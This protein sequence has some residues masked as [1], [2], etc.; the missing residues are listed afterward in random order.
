[1]SDILS[2]LLMR[3][4]SQRS[5]ATHSQWE[6]SLVWQLVHQNAVPVLPWYLGYISVLLFKLEDNCK[7]WEFTNLT[8]SNATPLPETDLKV[9]KRVHVIICAAHQGGR[10]LQVATEQW[11]CVR[12]TLSVLSHKI[13]SGGLKDNMKARMQNVLLIQLYCFSV[14]MIFLICGVNENILLKLISLL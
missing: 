1:M 12:S 2:A 3:T 5:C 4:E 8:L 7:S 14:K 13:Y 10:L 11:K 6:G 9:P